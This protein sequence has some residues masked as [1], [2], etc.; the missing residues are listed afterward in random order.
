MIAEP[1][2]EVSKASSRFIASSSCETRR[3]SWFQK[4]GIASQTGSS[5]KRDIYL[6]TG[7]HALKLAFFASSFASFSVFY[8][9]APGTISEGGIFFVVVEFASL[10]MQLRV[11]FAP[12]YPQDENPR[13][14]SKPLSHSSQSHRCIR[15]TERRL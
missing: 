8:F 6:C 3:S 5:S 10:G 9:I 1:N 2:V 12:V 14:F 4:Q 11:D 13:L 15:L 7:C